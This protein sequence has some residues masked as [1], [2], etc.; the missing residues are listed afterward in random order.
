LTAF[1]IARVQELL[2]HIILILLEV[3]ITFANQKGGTGKT[4]SVMNTGSALAEMGKKVLM[5][6]LDHQASLTKHSG[7][8]KPDINLSK[9]NIYNVLLSYVDAENPFLM[10][11]II[12]N[13]SENLWLVPSNNNLST[14][15]LDVSSRIGRE[16]I[17]Q[18]A[19][20]PIKSQ[21][22]YILIDIHPDLTVLNM[23]AFVITDKVV[24]VMSADYLT[25]DE[26]QPLLNTLATVKRL[27]NKELEIAGI[28][29]TRADF[30]T[31]HAKE[32][33]DATQE[34]YTG[35]RNLDTERG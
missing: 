12:K 10:S 4:T 6:D 13:V 7:Y 24:V 11:E 23:N 1:D 21:F 15:D 16:L 19:L 27:H 20:E 33:I 30:R 9:D 14:F 5:V 28:L 22:D 2:F 26:V 31:N 25:A 32:I 17:L 29:I 35:P 8:K 18:R 34:N 3:I